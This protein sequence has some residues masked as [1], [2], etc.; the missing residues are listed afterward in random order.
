MLFEGTDLCSPQLVSKVV[1]QQYDKKAL[2]S[3][4]L[5]SLNVKCTTRLLNRRFDI[6]SLRLRSIVRVENKFAYNRII[7]H[8]IVAKCFEDLGREKHCTEIYSFGKC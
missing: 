1:R 8:D 2:E 3:L 6:K 4:F 7:L 5:K